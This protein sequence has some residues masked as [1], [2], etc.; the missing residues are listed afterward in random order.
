MVI[1]ATG[2]KAESEHLDELGLMAGD[3]VR[4]DW[5]SMRTADPKVFAA[6]DG[7]FGPL[8]DRQRRCTTA[9]APPTT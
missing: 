4:T 8:D 7:A 9:T 5:D 1:L 2:Q 6:G 3:K